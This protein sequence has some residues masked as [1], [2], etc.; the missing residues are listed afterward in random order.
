M[1]LNLVWIIQIGNRK[2]KRKR[3]KRKE[4]KKP[5][6]GP[7]SFFPGRPIFT[8][9]SHAAHL[10]SSRSHLMTGGALVAAA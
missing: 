10:S 6:L 5:A 3:K 2:K 1:N 8:I 4:L 7:S 9:P